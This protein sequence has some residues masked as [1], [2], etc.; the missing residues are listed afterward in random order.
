[1]FKG[2]CVAITTPFE[3]NC[4]NIDFALLKKHTT[5]LV[6]N[7]ADS[8]LACGTTG[9]SA[10][11]SHDENIAVTK[12]ILEAVNGAIPVFGGA[13]SNDTR[14]SIALVKDLSKTDIAG[15]VVVTP[16]YN[17]TTQ[18]GLIQ[19]YKLIAEGTDLP[20]MLYNVPSRTSLN[21]LPKT[22]YELSKVDN[23]VATKEASGDLSQVAE[24][25]AIC[26]PN[27]D[28]FCGNDDQILPMLALGSVGCVSVAG[29]IIPKDVS[30]LVHSFL[31]G[32]IA[33]SRKLQLGMI[34]LIKALF[35]E[36]SPLPIKEA[37]TQMGLSSTVCR[38]PLFE[39]SAAGKEYLLKE[40]KNYGI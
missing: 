17:K 11:L 22:V 2:C 26:G 25:A 3:K 9:E 29:N 33:T 40:M 35:Y 19:H 23:I 20:I 18:D 14:K 31:K 30:D 21:M 36:T 12:A 32:D 8:I 16:Y 39:L 27:F 10:T 6:E 15:F 24:I 38:A 1:M 7:G 37:L 5:Y 28:I 34:P 13:G 4:D